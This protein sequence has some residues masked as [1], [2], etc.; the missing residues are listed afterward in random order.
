[1]LAIIAAPQLYGQIIY[2]Q[3][4]S[5]QARMIYSH[6]KIDGDSGAVLCR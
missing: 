5:G 1:M 6:W 3:P 2:D 4:G